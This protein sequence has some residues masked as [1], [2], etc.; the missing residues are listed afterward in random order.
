M[1][2]ELH[3]K[4]VD[5]I[6]AIGEKAWN[7]CAD[8]GYPFTRYTF[9]HALEHAGDDEA[10]CSDASGWQPR[11]LVVE[12]S[13]KVVALM[14]MYCKAH[15]YGE[16]IFD[17]AWAEAYHRN[18]IAYYPK[19]LSAIPFTPATGPRLLVDP[20]AIKTAEQRGEILAFIASQ[21]PALCT[22]Q[23]ASSFHLLFPGESVARGMAEQ[24]L[25]LR[26][27]F[28]YHW[29]NED[30]QRE[31]YRSF[32]DFCAHL[33][34]RKRKA[35]KKERRD[36]REQDIALSRMAGNEISAATWEEFYIFYQVTYAKRSG[37]G[38]YLPREFFLRVGETMPEQIMLVTARQEG[39][40]IAAALNFFSPTTLYGRY[41]GCIREAEFLH[42]E[43]CYY[44]GIEF[45]I[46]KG[47]DKFDAGAQG[48][49]KIQRGF[50][51]VD[52]WSAHWIAREDFRRAIADYLQREQAQNRQYM[53]AAMRLL[54]FRQANQASDAGSLTDPG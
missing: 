1:K 29:F 25:L 36:V 11:H 53:D 14:P 16:Y 15:S 43:L 30:A 21:V 32:E 52:T 22:G 8:A 23:N 19:L 47:L 10:A 45:C 9:L 37:H 24:G 49:H 12:R 28:Q 27:S 4:L 3:L 34:A 42:F 5:R 17:W 46:E 2:K 31:K 26:H 39:R 18:G 48:E 44:Q 51:P 7:Q 33:R 41:W 50:R 20:A 13:G 40:L 38:G 54:P 6:D 35:I